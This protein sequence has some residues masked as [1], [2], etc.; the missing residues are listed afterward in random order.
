MPK[1][2]K[3]VLGVLIGFIAWF[4]V[5]SIGNWVVRAL[6]PGYAEADV[7]MKFTLSMML[8]RLGVGAVSSLVAGLVCAMCVRSVPS[9]VRFLA[10]A[11]VVFFVP[12]HYAL[13]SQFPLWYH[14][15]FLLSIAPLVIAG[16]TLAGSVGLGRRSAA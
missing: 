7:A 15:V 5:A 3:I 14:A 9:S 6:A 12:V 13:W 11:L 1:A 8:A 2:I 16:G 4:I 10:V